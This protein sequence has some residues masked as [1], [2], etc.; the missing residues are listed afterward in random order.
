MMYSDS[1]NETDPTHQICKIT[2]HVSYHIIGAPCY[3]LHKFEAYYQSKSLNLYN[4][5]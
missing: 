4:I 3:N 1:E 5:I 2:G